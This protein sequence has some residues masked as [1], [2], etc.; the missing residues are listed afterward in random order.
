MHLGML[1][2]IYDVV[3]YENALTAFAAAPPHL[4][5][6]PSIP[7]VGEGWLKRLLVKKCNGSSIGFEDCVA[8]HV[9]WLPEMIQTTV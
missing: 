3:L 9:W 7:F 4:P 5:Y 8:G 1:A 2:A 6:P